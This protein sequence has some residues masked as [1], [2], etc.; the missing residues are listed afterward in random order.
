MQGLGSGEVTV[1]QALCGAR[2][3]GPTLSPSA[4]GR[5]CWDARLR[6]GEKGADLLTQDSHSGRNALSAGSAD[7]LAHDTLPLYRE[8]DDW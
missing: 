3:R 1:A 2:R 7:V 6:Q 8:L 4:E 5:V